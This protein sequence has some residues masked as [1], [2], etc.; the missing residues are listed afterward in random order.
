[1]KILPLPASN[2]LAE[3]EVVIAAAARF[4]F[5]EVFHYWSGY[6]P[7]ELAGV[8][9]TFTGIG[10]AALLAP[11]SSD[12]GSGAAGY[13]LTLSGIEP[14]LADAVLAQTY[15]QRPVTLWRVIFDRAGTTPLGYAVFHRGRVDTIEEVE[16]IGG[17]AAL[18]ISIEGGMRDLSRTGV[19]LNSDADQRLLGGPGD[20][21]M[22]RTAIAGVTTL[23][24]GKQP[25]APAAQVL[26]GAINVGAGGGL[27]PLTVALY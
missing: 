26:P 24:W 10:A 22:R 5:D 21:S 9:A 15:R 3:D 18:E 11:I 19:R 2:A 1:M 16:T 27:I 20:G 6:G 8:G 4:S 23:S 13:R 14:E 25:P 17:D 7:L 12:V